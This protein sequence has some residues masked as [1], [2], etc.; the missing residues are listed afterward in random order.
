MEYVNM[1]ITE[2]LDLANQLLVLEFRTTPTGPPNLEPLSQNRQVFKISARGPVTAGALV[3]EM[4]A[5]V[6]EVHTVPPPAHQ[7]IAITFTLGTEQGTI[8]GY[9]SGSIHMV[10]DGHK[11]LINGYGQILTVTGAYADLFLAEVFVSS[12]VPRVDGRALGENGRMTISP[13]HNRAV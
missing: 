5:S 1:K 11:W 12:E 3:G 9:Y 6:T 10:E 2:S 7:G 13:R 4:S 8:G